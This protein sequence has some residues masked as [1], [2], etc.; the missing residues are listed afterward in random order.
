MSLCKYYTQ[1]NNESGEV[2]T[3]I[4]FPDLTV[5][6]VKA[7]APQ[8]DSVMELLKAG[9]TPDEVTESLNVTAT[10]LER[11]LIPVSDRISVMNGNVFVDGDVV[12]NAITQHL[13]Q[14]MES[15]DNSYLSV[16]RFYENLLQNPSEASREQLFE[17]LVNHDMFALT[18]DGEVFGYKGVSLDHR[19]INRGSAYVDGKLVTGT[20]PYRNGS[21][22]TMPRSQV[23]SD[24]MRPCAPGL[25]IG[26]W[27]YAS[28]WG[29]LV[30]GVTFNP[31]DVV[32][33]PSHETSKLRVC[34]LRITDQVEG[35][36][37]RT[38]WDVNDYIDDYDD[39]DDYYD[40]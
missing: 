22:V 7:D 31:R 16:V 18:E 3:V 36:T 30:L 24:P 8:Y 4:I 14:K 34:R 20:I 13:L 37:Q 9:A 21:V 19:S 5:E 40:D 25:H 11:A 28:N 33:V 15:G 38:S 6:S 32:S 27:N 17:W 1:R 23:E 29:R 12:H 10:R 2:T 26:T 35:P 39:H